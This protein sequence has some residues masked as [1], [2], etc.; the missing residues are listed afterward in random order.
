MYISVIF[1][2]TTF[3]KAQYINF[4]SFLF[5]GSPYTLLILRAKWASR[6]EAQFV[7]TNI[8]YI[9][10]NT[11]EVMVLLRCISN[12]VSFNDMFRL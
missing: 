6:K 11:T 2:A 12:I 8:D 5:I 7:T 3:L 10:I 1:Y 4:L 9:Y